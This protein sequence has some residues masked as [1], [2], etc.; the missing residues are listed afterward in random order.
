MNRLTENNVDEY[1]VIAVMGDTSSDK[2]SLLS[3]IEIVELP[4][5]DNL[6]TSYIRS[7]HIDSLHGYSDI[8]NYEA[9]CKVS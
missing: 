2:L 1:I 9:F 3:N 6:T 4:S 5:T 8:M 7:G